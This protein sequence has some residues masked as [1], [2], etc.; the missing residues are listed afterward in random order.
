[1]K[2]GVI[3]AGLVGSTAA[4]ALIMRGVGREIVLVDLDAARAGAEADDLYHAVPFAHQLTV[5]AG[6]YAQLAGCRLVVIAAGVS[7]EPGETRLQ[8]LSRNAEVFRQVI[9]NILKYAP[10]AILLVATNPVDVMTHLAAH[11][12]GQLG[13]PSSRVIGSGTT[14]D[15][16][17]FRALLGRRLQI[18]PQHVHA[19]VLGEHGDSEVL[20]WSLVTAASLPLDDFCRDAGI[21]LGPQER[22]EIDAGVRRAAYSIIEGK[23]ATYYGIGSAIARI[24]EVILRDQRALLTVCTPLED[25]LGVQNVTVAMPNLLGGA[26]VIRTL[27]QPLTSQEQEALRRSASIVRQ[28]IT[29]L[30]L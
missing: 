12:A 19:Y 9:P 1:M 23:G 22:D 14:L 13:L 26:G 15:T 18:D 8:L 29:S 20:A 30:G 2:I 10:E 25:L 16:A 27:S 6:D 4:Y 7:Q 28:A 17:R 5:S 24:C 11:F 3:G 21:Q